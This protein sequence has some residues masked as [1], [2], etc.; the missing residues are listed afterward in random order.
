M[1]C[2]KSLNKREIFSLKLFN[3]SLE[4]INSKMDMINYL[5]F[6][7]EYIHVKCF[8]FDDLQSLCLGFIKKPKIFESNRFV[9]INAK[10]HKKLKEILKSFKIKNDLTQNDLKIYN[11][12]S[13]EV[14]L[15]IY[16]FRE[17]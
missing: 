15:L 14:K 17:K 8:L 9:T 1:I 6:V 11:L 3:R 10:S 16:K 13:D 12:L 4:I 7:H 5:K 2:S